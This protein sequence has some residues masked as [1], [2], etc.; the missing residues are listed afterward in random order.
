MEATGNAGLKDQVQALKWVQKNIKSFGGD[1][2][3]VTIFGQSAGSVSVH[4]LVLSPLTQG[5][6]HKAIMQSG[7][8]TCPWSRG[9]DT[10]QQIAQNCSCVN[11]NKTEMLNCLQHTSKE[12]LLAAQTKLLLQTVGA[13]AKAPFG[14]TIEVENPQALITKEPVDLIKSGKYNHV[15]LMFGYTDLEGILS[16][17]DTDAQLQTKLEDPVPYSFRYDH[18]SEDFLKLRKKINQFYF[19]NDQSDFRN[20]EVAFKVGTAGGTVA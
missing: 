14:P 3:N 8:V 6:F 1:P 10:T 18:G 9:R 13:G 20:K 11:T 7:T 17:M 5:L 16:M 15:P 4:F 12:T 19:G 2:S